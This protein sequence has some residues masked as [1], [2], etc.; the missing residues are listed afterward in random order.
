MNCNHPIVL[1]IY[2]DSTH[3]EIAYYFCVNCSKK[4]TERFGKEII[5]EMRH[6]M[7]NNL[8]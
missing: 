4:S 8:Q 6:E 3:L 1:E 5:S 2:T 7:L